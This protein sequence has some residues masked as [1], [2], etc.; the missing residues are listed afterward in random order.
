MAELKP[1]YLI[2]GED[3][4]R[5]DA[6][7]D[8]LRGRAASEGPDASLE[9]LKDDRSSGDDAADAIRALTL[10]S[11]RRYVL[12]DGVE[13][14]KERDVK[15]VKAA[16]A[17]RPPET[18]VVLIAHGKSPAAL[19]KTVEGC[20][21]DVRA[22]E[23]PQRREYAK[24]ARARA[25]EL[26]LELD[27]E[28]ADLLIAR[29]ARDDKNRLRQSALMRELEKLSIYVGEGAEV[30]AETVARLTTSAVEA[31]TYELADAVIEGNRKRAL[32][33]AED[34][35]S[36]G[37]DMM[38][39]LFALLRQLRNA[40]R[41]WAMMNSGRS[42]GDVQS[43]LRVPTFVARRIVSQT[44]QMDSDRFERAFELLADLDY[45]IRGVGRFDPETALTLTLNDATAA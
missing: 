5:I 21:G 32:E 13:D 22:Y 12:I 45:A 4:A 33:I 17:D 34:L 24:W 29:A 26:G 38:Y 14:W 44:K 2:W 28:G 41:A 10:S 42:L 6:W 16:L 9:V 30:D 40:H 19:A 1:V 37:E 35:R 15:E 31:R 39:I 3:E 8:R 25:A 20:G 23:G 11:G 7:R 43:A 36:R 27:R 18:I